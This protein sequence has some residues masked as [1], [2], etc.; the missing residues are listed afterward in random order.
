MQFFSKLTL[1]LNTEARSEILKRLFSGD[2]S[3]FIC[4]NTPFTGT[5]EQ[6][7]AFGLN[8]NRIETADGF[9]I[10]RLSAFITYAL[11]V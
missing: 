7:N 5:C 6:I 1:I 10:D 9:H 2:H 11:T 8:I 3:Y 4:E